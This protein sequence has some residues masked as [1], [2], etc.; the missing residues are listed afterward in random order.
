MMAIMTSEPSHRPPR[1]LAE[2]NWEQVRCS[3]E[4]L[5]ALKR[6]GFFI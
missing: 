2:S 6:R 4:T 1:A 3:P 5:P